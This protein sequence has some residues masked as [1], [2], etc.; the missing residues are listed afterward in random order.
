LVCDVETSDG[1]GE[2]TSMG[3]RVFGY[4]VLVVLALLA[5]VISVTVG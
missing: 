1:N 4:G 2:Q 5:L 3:R